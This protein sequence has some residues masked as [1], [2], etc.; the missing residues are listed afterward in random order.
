MT[1]TCVIANP[2]HT[3]GQRE[4]KNINNTTATTS[5]IQHCHRY[6]HFHLHSHSHSYSY[7]LFAFA[8]YSGELMISPN[9]PPPCH[10]HSRPSALMRWLMQRFTVH[11]WTRNHRKFQVCNFEYIYS[12]FLF[13]YFS[14]N[15]TSTYLVLI[16]IFVLYSTCNE[17]SHL[18]C[19]TIFGLQWWRTVQMIST[20]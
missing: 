3:Q 9:Q 19:T 5:A 8:F 2:R 1:S 17:V 6:S 11:K 7:S 4:N 13:V 12:L 14:Y 16:S 18:Q 15:N 20:R 10:R